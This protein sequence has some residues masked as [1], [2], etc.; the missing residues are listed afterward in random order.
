MVTG[1]VAVAPFLSSSLPQPV[2][3]PA[4]LSFETATAQANGHTLLLLEVRD[5]N[6]TPTPGGMVQPSGMAAT[7]RLE[8][9]TNLTTWETVAA[10]N[11]P[12][13]SAARFFRT[14]LLLP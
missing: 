4:S 1:V 3:G 12:A 10:T 8:T 6:T 7:L 11:Y 14:S 9:S 13:P 5:V 2:L